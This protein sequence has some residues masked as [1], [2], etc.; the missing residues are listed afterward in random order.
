MAQA[1][2]GDSPSTAS[3]RGDL[4]TRRHT[5]GHL[6]GAGAGDVSGHRVCTALQASALG[7][8]S[9]VAR[10]VDESSTEAL[11]AHNSVIASTEATPSL[12]Q[13]G[14]GTELSLRRAGTTW[15]CGRPVPGAEPCRPSLST[16]VSHGQTAGVCWAPPS[17]APAAEA[18]V[19]PAVRAQPQ[20]SWSRVLPLLFHDPVPETRDMCGGMNAL[21]PRRAAAGRGVEGTGRPH[22]PLGALSPSLLCKLFLSSSDTTTGKR[23]HISA[24]SS[25]SRC[26]YHGSWTLATVWM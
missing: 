2:Y 11:L 3:A 12:T 17:S 14:E 18:E 10:G 23:G 1:A 16:G 13:A 26:R 21:D 25:A 19:S 7:L 22:C 4:F 20:H 6:E 5:K 24:S 9:S 15:C 8:G